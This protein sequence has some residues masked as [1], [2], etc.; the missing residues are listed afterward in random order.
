PKIFHEVATL[1]IN[2]VYPTAEEITR[3]GMM[4]IDRKPFEQV[5]YASFFSGLSVKDGLNRIRIGGSS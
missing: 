5:L 1:L 3:L 4:S 2:K